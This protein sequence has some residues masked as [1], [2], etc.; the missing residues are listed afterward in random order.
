MIS[1]VS[2]LTRSIVVVPCA[3]TLV[4]TVALSLSG[5]NESILVLMCFGALTT[6][7]HT[8]IFHSLINDWHLR[9][10]P[11]Y[12]DV[13]AYTCVCTLSSIA[14]ELIIRLFG[15]HSIAP[16]QQIATVSVLAGMFGYLLYYLF[17]LCAYKAGFKRNVV[18]DVGA[19]EE[20]EIK[21]ALACR[22]I[23]DQINPLPINEL[24]SLILAK[25]VS[26]VDAI[27]TSTT[28]SIGIDNEGLLIRA[29]LA[30]VP[31]HDVEGLINRLWGRVRINDINHVHFLVNATDQTL[32]LRA[33]RGFKAIFEP[34][35]A[36]ILLVLLM[37]FLIIVGLVIKMDSEGPILYS[38]LRT[39]HLGR[40]IRVIKFRSMRNDA[41]KNGPQWSQSNDNRITR[42][43]KI[44]RKTRIDELPQL[45]NVIRGEMGFV[46]PRPER[47]EFYQKVR[48]DIPLFPLRTLIKPGIT[49][50]AQ[51]FAGY[52]G[53]VE[54]SRV[55]LEFDLFYLQNM[56]PRMDIIVL[57]KTIAVAI[58]G[59][60]RNDI[61]QQILVDE[62]NL[63][64]A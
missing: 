14:S 16:L 4:W 20:A 2:K 31:V 49:G 54:E 27:I 63:R 28:H 18:F 50:W 62:T 58:K 32:A 24:R 12:A 11:R 38:Q 8:S 15:N 46:G 39:G 42:V 60:E 17:S 30:G 57:G 61:P 47:P 48:E 37:P 29:H 53:S 34:V 7:L 13:L 55:K 1:G 59:E 35:L 19:V 21:K 10:I 44:L 45:W 51:V 3:Q 22:V 6:V 33:Y 25:R 64:R 43:G 9:A 56:S 36:C 5:W 40:A 23:L 26:L 52:A 41:E